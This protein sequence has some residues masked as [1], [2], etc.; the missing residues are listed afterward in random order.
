MISALYSLINWRRLWDRF[1][2]AAAF[3]VLL[4]A[5][6]LIPVYLFYEQQP[7]DSY[8]FLDFLEPFS[9]FLDDFLVLEPFL[10]LEALGGAAVSLFSELEAWGAWGE[11][12]AV[13]S[14]AGMFTLGLCTA[15][16]AVSKAVLAVSASAGAA[17]SGVYS[18]M[19]SIRQFKIRQS[20]SRV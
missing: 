6:A 15:A 20:V 2:N 7:F 13:G 9:P 17:S 10:A 16:S 12:T 11:E 14:G 5:A 19:S 3:F 1:F 4:M 18:T 8:F